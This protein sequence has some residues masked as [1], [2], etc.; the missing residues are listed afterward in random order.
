MGYKPGQGLG[1]NNQGITAPIEAK[2][3]PKQ[4]GMGTFGAEMFAYKSDESDD[5]FKSEKE[6]QKE[7]TKKEI[8]FKKGS[9]NVK[10]TVKYMYKSVDEIINEN[11]FLTNEDEDFNTVKVIDMTGPEKKVYSGYQQFNQKSDQKGKDCFDSNLIVNLEENLDLLLSMSEEEIIRNYRKVK[12][13][14]E[15]LE[16]L[17]SEENRLKA[18]IY[19]EKESVNALEE[20]IHRLNEINVKND[21]IQ[22]KAHQCVQFSKDMCKNCHKHG[23]KINLNDIIYSFEFPIIE[24]YID[25]WSPL[26]AT[27]FPLQLFR[28]YKSAF[29]AIDETI[30]DNLMWNVWMP[31]VRR[32]LTSWPSIRQY[33]EIINLLEMWKDLLQ[34]WLLDNILDQIIIPK[35]EEEVESW[36]PLTDTVPV[37]SWIHP[38]LPLLGDRCLETIY[39]PIRHKLANALTNWHP[40]DRSANLILEPWKNVFQ[41]NVWESFLILNILPKLEQAFESFI[42]NP[43]QQ[44]LDVWHW[45]IDWEDMLSIQHSVSILIKHF[46]PKWLQILYTWLSNSP[47]YDEISRWYLGWKQMFSPKLI[48]QASVQEGFKRALEMMNYAVSAPSGIFSYKLLDFNLNKVSEESCKTSEERL[49]SKSLIFEV[50]LTLKQLIEKKADEMSL[51]F[52]QIPNRYHESFQVYKFGKLSIYLD[53]HNNLFFNNN[54]I[55]DPISLTDLCTK[56]SS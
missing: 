14:K 51:L 44:R 36:D 7:R 17:N 8:K 48:S 25:S 18:S 11:E 35:L 41:S 30:Y 56:A 32:D 9:T 47:N 49:K 50:N 24:K 37:H 29:C 52:L 23:H 54:N 22:F 10:Q 13:E 2:K 55:W 19:A 39:A 15:K 12:Q 20:L 33:D 46:F 43:H 16:S 6:R 38:W 28:D 21:N 53:N 42:I 34:E 31:I 26:T 45:F 5:E 27:A 1:K 40:S 4:V 3:R